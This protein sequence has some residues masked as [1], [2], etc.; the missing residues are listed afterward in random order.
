MK[1][2]FIINPVAGKG[3]YQKEL[4][5]NI[6]TTLSDTDI[7]YE[8]YLTKY[9][10]DASEYVLAKCKE[11]IPYVFYA[12]GGDG[13]FHEVINSAKGYS[14]VSVGVIP[15]G[16]GN[17]FIK[18]FTNIKNFINIKAQ[19][20]GHTEPIDLVKIGNE[21]SAAVCNIGFDADAAF[22]MHK[23][24]AIPFVNGSACYYLSVLYCLMR[25]LGKSFT[26]TFDDDE[27]IIDNF[28]LCVAANGH[29]YGG[30]Y[31][32]APKACINDGII[33]V[34]LVKK[35][36]RLKIIK[37]IG[38]YKKGQHVDNIAFNKYITYKKC[39]SLKIIGDGP[40]NLC[41]DGENYVYDEVTFEV[42][43]NAVNFHMPEGVSFFNEIKMS[44]N[45]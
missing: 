10:N 36:S 11:N 42:A 44:E 34:C 40:I 45:K 6:N 23:F 27:T 7:S 15:C 25:K 16:S 32:C 14:H 18:N 24:K 37:L 8:I 5:D 31:M 30:G 33:D 20:N 38:A 1:H 13:T 41:I 29:S 19:V 12:C 22:N 9:K 28:L 43:S 21:Y 4:V 17:D 39:K 2:I 35:L 3:K 26:V